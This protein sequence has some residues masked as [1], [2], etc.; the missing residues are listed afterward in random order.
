MQSL[1][2]LVSIIFTGIVTLA[3]SFFAFNQRTEHGSRLFGIV[4]LDVFFLM[5]TSILSMLSQT[6]QQASFWFNLRTIFYAL[7]PMTWVFF[8]LKYYRLGNWISRRAIVFAW[9][10]PIMTIIFSIVPGLHNIWIVREP[11]FYRTDFFWQANLNDRVPGFWF[12]VNTVYGILLYLTGLSIILLDAIRFHRIKKSISILMGIVIV[13]VITGAVLA[14]FSILPM[15]FPNPFIV[16]MELATVLEVI[17]VLF[18]GFLRPGHSSETNVKEDVFAFQN[19]RFLNILVLIFVIATAGISSIGVV[20]M[21]NYARQYREQTEAQLTSVSLLK[22][23]DITNWRQERFYD[24]NTFFNNRAF[25]D[26]I[27]SYKNDPSNLDLKYQI[28]SWFSGLLSHDEYN[29]VSFLDT[30]VEELLTTGNP[31]E[32]CPL[33]LGEDM[34][35]PLSDHKVEMI[36]FHR[37]CENSPVYLAMLIPIYSSS[38]GIP[39]GVVLVRINPEVSLYPM[40]LNWPVPSES[41]ETAIIRKEGD[42]VV[43]LSKLRYDDAPVLS[44]FVDISDGDHPS[45]LAAEG[46]VGIVDGIN[47]R[48]HEV[49]ADVRPVP[50]TPWFLV[51]RIDKSEALEPITIRQR[52]TWA[53]FST[54]I[55]I[56]SGGLVLLWRQQQLRLLAAHNEAQAEI[57]EGKRR[58][59][60]AEKLAHLGF[61][62]WDIKSGNVEWSDEVYEIFQLD[63]KTFSPRIDSIL[64]RSPWPEEQARGQELIER[65]IQTHQPGTYEQKFLLPDSSIGYYTST[66]QGIFDKN[67]ELVAIVGSVIDTT[68]KTI[69]EQALRESEKK[70]RKLFEQAATGVAILDTQSGRYLDINQK[71]CDFLGYSKEEMLKKT[72]Q[73]VTAPDSVQE[74]IKDNKMLLEGKI[75]EFSIEKQYIRKDGKRVWGNLIGSPLWDEKNQN[76]AYQHIAIVNDITEQKNAEFAL[77]ESEKK[78]REM[79]E[80]LDEGY[81]S[82]TFNGIILDHNQSFVKLMG[83][84]VDYNLRGDSVLPIWQDNRDRKDYLKELLENGSISS[85]QIKAKQIKTNKKLTLLISAHLI[86]DNQGKPLRI[87]GVTL[88]ITSRIKQEEE[89][90][91]AQKELQVLLD[92]ADQSRRALLTIVEDQKMAQAEIRQLN[93]TLEERVNNRTAQ[94]KASNEELESFAYSISH[95]LRAPLRAIDGYSNILAQDYGKNLDAEGL[96]L[97]SIIRSSVK[98]MDDLITDL[99]ALSRVGRSELKFETIE[100]TDLVLSIYKELITPEEKEKY[101]FNVTPLPNVDADPTLIRHV[102]I[103]LISNAIKYS[104]PR[105]NPEIIIS[106]KKTARNCVYSIKDNGVGFNPLYKDKLFVL[107]QRLHKPSD[108]EG[109]GV[110]LAIVQRIIRR[111]NGKIWAD[112]KPDAGAEFSFSLPRKGKI[113]E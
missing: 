104:A 79:V 97:L 43:Y 23:T 34:E 3:L 49:I 16:G 44:K 108:F 71:Y 93:K 68:E 39:L 60:E 33:H 77:R 26:L 112:G 110:G 90:L 40:I 14:V 1:I 78:F 50:D 10:I 30:E 51:S 61:W 45:A 107:F 37:D 75:T 46:F 27:E 83:Y 72:F 105:E 85:Y 22:V 63:P 35:A 73:D 47:Y 56:L 89:I 95:D 86:R 12:Y 15:D 41:A 101:S 55:L 4:S 36:D 69:Q 2:I 20:S 9:I 54:I 11:S 24:A 66:F 67:D 94:L 48:G 58:L 21:K 106:G 70:F 74:N 17:A 100:M 8:I 13:T 62:Y 113:D 76:V 103:N 98:N 5:L 19:R 109:T 92:Q 31:N 29:K 32:A 6:E 84:S 80:N 53:L 91:A 25:S 42:Q 65:S 111:H 96:R 52:I 59:R 81:Y 102:W 87:E 88:D 18:T 99:L 28:L 57:L 7:L 82:V 38:N 64:E